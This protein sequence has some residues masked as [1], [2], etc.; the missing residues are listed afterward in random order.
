VGER[1]VPEQWRRQGYSG[2][3]QLAWPIRA[4]EAPWWRDA[5]GYGIQ[6]ASLGR[7]EWLVLDVEELV[8]GARVV[9]VRRDMDA[10]FDFAGP[11]SFQVGG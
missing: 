2:V 1:E 5:I 9:L 8:I 3:F 11:M 6:H 7:Q 4:S 10:V